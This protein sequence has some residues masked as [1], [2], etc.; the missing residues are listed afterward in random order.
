M[1]HNGVECDEFRDIY[2]DEGSAVVNAKEYWVD[3]EII[4]RDV[5]VKVKEGFALSGDFSYG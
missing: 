3:G 1:I 4:Q 2:I 5:E